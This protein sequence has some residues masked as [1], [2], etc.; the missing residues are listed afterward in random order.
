LIEALRYKAEWGK[1]AMRSVSAKALG[2]IGDSRAAGALIKAALSD[3]NE[4]V[5]KNAAEALEKIGYPTFSV[6]I[7]TSSD[8][9]M[10][11]EKFST[12]VINKDVVFEGDKAIKYEIGELPYKEPT[13]LEKWPPGMPVDMAKVGI[14]GIRIKPVRSAGY[15]VGIIDEKCTECHH[16]NRFTSSKSTLNNVE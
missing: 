7:I 12:L 13:G 15:I 2:K 16:C 6:P 8:G 1:W 10:D 11:S 9:I 3:P 4:K 5:R 14:A